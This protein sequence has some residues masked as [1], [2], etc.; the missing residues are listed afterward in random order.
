MRGKIR[1]YA[2][3]RPLNKSEKDMGSPNAVEIPD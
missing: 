2:R 1:V 3:V